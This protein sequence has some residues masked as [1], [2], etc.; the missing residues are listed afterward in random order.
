MKY[1][2]NTLKWTV[3]SDKIR[4]QFLRFHVFV[5]LA[6][7]P[8]FTT[9]PDNRISQHIFE[10]YRRLLPD[11]YTTR[12]DNSDWVDQL[13]TNHAVYGT[14]YRSLFVTQ[15]PETNNGID[16]ELLTVQAFIDNEYNN[17]KVKRGPEQT[18]EYYVLSPGKIQPML[19][20]ENTDEEMKQ[21]I[22]FIFLS[23]YPTPRF[24]PW[25]YLRPGDDYGHWLLL[26]VYNNPK[27][28][29]I[30]DS[31][32]PDNEEY[33]H[34]QVSALLRR[35]LPS[36]QATHTIHTIRCTTQKGNKCGLHMLY[37]L[38]RCVQYLTNISHDGVQDP[39]RTLLLDPD[40]DIYTARLESTL[41]YIQH[42]TQHHHLTQGVHRM[43]GD[44][45]SPPWTN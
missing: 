9:H 29:L 45:Q 38:M 24:L 18:Q 13:T 7:G 23:A 15:L 17:K 27:S 19:N 42:K 35:R 39:L 3:S 34:E 40:E 43:F 32:G 8:Y 1:T 14:A 20:T 6:H 37:N 11:N 10:F 36:G 26:V 4:T 30:L 41:S 16:L 33:R 2:L 28:V 12:G 31:L 44:H 21:L 25:L 5:A 22:N